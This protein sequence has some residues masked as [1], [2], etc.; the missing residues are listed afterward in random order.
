MRK[1]REPIIIALSII[2]SYI[3]LLT[4]LILHFSSWSGITFDYFVK[5]I[6]KLFLI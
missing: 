6:Y 2:I 3:G 1:I 5:A 4:I